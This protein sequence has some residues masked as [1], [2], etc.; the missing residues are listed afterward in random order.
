MKKIIEVLVA[1]VM[2]ASLEQP[3]VETDH[4]QMVQIIRHRAQKNQ[5]KLTCESRQGEWEVH[6][7][8]CI[9]GYMCELS[10]SGDRK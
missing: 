4:D 5:E 3:F 7:H 1:G 2:L 10:G 6:W 8:K 9:C